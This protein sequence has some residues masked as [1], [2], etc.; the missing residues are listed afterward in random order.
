MQFL[1]SSRDF[2]IKPK[3]GKKRLCIGTQYR[4]NH[5]NCG[6][7][8]DR[9][10]IAIALMYCDVSSTHDMY[11]SQVRMNSVRTKKLFNVSSGTSAD[12]FDDDR[13]HCREPTD[14]HFTPF[15]D[16]PFVDDT[17][18]LFDEEDEC[19]DNDSVHSCVSID[20]RST[21]PTDTSFDGHSLDPF[22]SADERSTTTAD[23]QSGSSY[24][25]SSTPLVGYH[26]P[27]SFKTRLWRDIKTIR[28][29]FEL[30]EVLFRGMLHHSKKHCSQLKNNDQKTSQFLFSTTAQ[31]NTQVRHVNFLGDLCLPIKTPN[32]VRGCKQVA[33]NH[34]H[35]SQDSSHPC[36]GFPFSISKQLSLTV[37]DKTKLM[38]NAFKCV[39][40]NAEKECWLAAHDCN[41]VPNAP[42]S[43]L[44]RNG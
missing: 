44:S 28:L 4:R 31:P 21:V 23:L 14:I 32:D 41:Q 18:H 36:D 13:S 30:C 38:V 9:L 15:D 22:V 35:T 27:R 7:L 1:R 29:G 39:A 12:R 10:D 19:L 34:T 6:I 8:V 25:L 20:E 16:Q 43:R 33:K 26:V 17:G 2:C 11:F 37:E 24:Q 5:H 40:T 3:F 42:C